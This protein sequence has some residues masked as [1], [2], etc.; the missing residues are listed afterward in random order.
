VDDD[1]PREPLARPEMPPAAPAAP[2]AGI[3]GEVL[4]L[5][6]ARAAR[7]TDGAVKPGEWV[8][9]LPE[10]DQDADAVEGERVDLPATLYPVSL[11]ETMLAKDQARR[12]VIAPWLRSKAERHAVAL[13][14]AKH[15]GTTVAFHA[16]RCPWYAGRLLGYAPRGL[17][18]AVGRWSRW[19][20]DAEGAPVR[21][22]AV[23]TED[24]AE[25]LRSSCARC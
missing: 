4:D 12:P 22:A 20:W 8:I 24:A 3:G 13:W 1:E 6:K 17:A 9:D 7:D 19:L 2:A 15:Y 23:R 21:A 18:R 10:T 25:Y 16:V 14:T 5:G 11:A